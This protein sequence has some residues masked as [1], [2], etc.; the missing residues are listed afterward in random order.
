MVLMHKNYKFSEIMSVSPSWILY[1][2]QFTML[3]LGLFLGS[4][5]C[6][7]DLSFIIISIIN[8]L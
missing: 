4:L 6:P 3:T 8:Y 1:C 7:V 2:K 5:F